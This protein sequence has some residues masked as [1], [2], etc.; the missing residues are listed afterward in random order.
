MARFL[1]AAWFE[2]VA[3]ATGPAPAKP[4]DLVLQQVVTGTPEGEVTYRVLVS[5]DEA[6]IQP[7]G[8]GTADVTLTSDYSTAAAIAEGQLSA[9]SALRQGRIRVGGDLSR[10][11]ERHTQLTIDPVPASVRARTT[12]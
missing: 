4:V 3:D 10:L 6:V 2:D 5:D 1:S 8:D 7:G 9:Q 11:T 12:F